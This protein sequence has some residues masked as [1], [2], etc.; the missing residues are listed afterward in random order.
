MALHPRVRSTIGSFGN[1]ISSSRFRH[2]DNGQR[3]AIRGARSFSQAKKYDQYL[4]HS[5]DSSSWVN[6]LP[7]QNG[8]TQ[9]AHHSK[10]SIPASTSLY[11]EKAALQ[12][13]TDQSCPC[14]GSTLSPKIDGATIRKRHLHHSETSIVALFRLEIKAEIFNK[15]DQLW[16]R[17]ILPELERLL[18]LRHEK[19]QHDST[20][21]NSP[22]SPTLSK[23]EQP[24][25]DDPRQHREEGT[26]AD[27]RQGLAWSGKMDERSDLSAGR[28]LKR[29]EIGGRLSTSDNGE[30]VKSRK[31]L[32][33]SGLALFMIYVIVLAQGCESASGRAEEKPERRNT[34]SRGAAVPVGVGCVLM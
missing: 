11:Q 16:R 4:H 6:S 13:Q 22:P 34:S 29:Q 24:K 18:L 15:Q 8:T 28:E 20:I 27:N 12:Q 26:G 32:V 1:T 3:R 30:D 14:C 19:T 2:R 25:S 7:E 33:A 9:Y 23:Q 21:P 10:S 17:V 5:Q 31:D